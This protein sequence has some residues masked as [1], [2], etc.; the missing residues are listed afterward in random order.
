MTAFL[1]E[2]PRCVFIHVPKTGGNTIRNVIFERNYSGPYFG[3]AFDPEWERLFS[4]AFVRNPFDRVVSAWKMFTQGVA[5][6]DWQLPEDFDPNL[7]LRDVLELA[8][9][10]AAEFGHPRFNQVKM[11]AKI[12]LKNHLLPQVHPYYQLS[13]AKFVGR[14]ETYEADLKHIFGALGIGYKP[15][16]RSHFTTRAPYQDYFCST[17]IALAR[18]LYRED[19]ERF[20]Y[21]F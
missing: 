6:S 3:K 20:G 8:L 16:P 15:P 5:N 9:D 12:R 4:F 13:K 17:T 11:N 14:F 18:E 10:P 19:L 1:I 21:D 2:D 7:T